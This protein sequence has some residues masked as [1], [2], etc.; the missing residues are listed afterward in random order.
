MLYTFH[1]QVVAQ[2]TK[3]GS[4]VNSNTVRYLHGDHLGS[5]TATTTA[6]GAIEHRQEYSPWGEARTTGT[7]ATDITTTS[8][9]YTGQ[10]KDGTGLLYYHARYYDPA[11]A[12]FVS[13]DS[14]VPGAA[15]GTGG[16]GT[17]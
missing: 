9:D 7:G 15:S 16:A 1:G 6:T 14:I 13:A 2:R 11:L 10:R 3:A 12:R 17:V 5:I 8:L 4:P